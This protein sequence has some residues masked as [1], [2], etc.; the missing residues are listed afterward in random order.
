MIEAGDVATADLKD[1]EIDSYDEVIAQARDLVKH[2]FL[3]PLVVDS[4]SKGQ[5]RIE[6]PL[7][8]D[9]CYLEYEESIYTDIIPV[10]TSSISVSLLSKDSEFEERGEIHITLSQPS[11]HY[12]VIYSLDAI[13]GGDNIWL[14][15]LDAVEKISDLSSRIKIALDAQQ[16]ASQTTNPSVLGVPHS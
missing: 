8:D 2:P 12:R 11:N 3:Q 14:D 13:E 16:S 15:G 6:F 10:Y 7:G 1:E 5:S 4:F 9:V